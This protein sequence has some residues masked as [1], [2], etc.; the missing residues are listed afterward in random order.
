MHASAVACL[1][2]CCSAA[3]SPAWPREGSSLLPVV[4]VPPFP[5]KGNQARPPLLLPAAG[6]VSSVLVEHGAARRRMAP[7]ALRPAARIIIGDQHDP[8]S[9]HG[10][11]SSSSACRALGTHP[12]FR[13]SSCLLIGRNVQ[14]SPSQLA[15]I[16]CNKTCYCVGHGG[17]HE[18]TYLLLR[19]DAAE[20]LGPKTWG[21]RREQ[22]LQPLGPPE[23]PAGPQKSVQR[24]VQQPLLKMNSE[25]SCSGPE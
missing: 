16:L 4:M 5:A 6:R 8:A 24:I 1:P 25:G 10:T 11:A 22:V 12:S 18:P 14:K 21:G 15:R 13:S 2:V 17:T 19:M 9:T 7:P 3:C 20:R 23:E